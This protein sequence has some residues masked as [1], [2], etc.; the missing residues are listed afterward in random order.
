MTRDDA[1]KA[2]VRLQGSVDTKQVLEFVEGYPA[3]KQET[4]LSFLSRG[5]FAG[6]LYGLT[7]YETI[8][9]QAG[10]DPGQPGDVESTIQDIRSALARVAAQPGGLDRLRYI[11]AKAWEQVMEGLKAD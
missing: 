7:N 9:E 6:V 8:S 2:L 1:M 10:R 3:F 4:L 11:N 5:F